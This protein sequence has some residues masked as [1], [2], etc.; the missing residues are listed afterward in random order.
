MDLSGG[1]WQRVALA[2][3]LYASKVGGRI[4]VLDEPTASLDVGAEIALFDQLLEHAVGCT[5]IVVSHRF[6]TVR[7]AQRIVVLTDG[8]VAEDGSHDELLA[9]GG[10]YSTLFTM[11][12]SRFRDGF[13]AEHDNAERGSE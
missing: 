9:M 7:R 12:A 13:V 10:R 5:A 11:Q 6:S 8:R 4:L 2:R 1:Q 3:A